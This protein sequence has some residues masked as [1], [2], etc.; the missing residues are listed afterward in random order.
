M[1]AM[2]SCSILILMIDRRNNG[3]LSQFL[4]FFDFL[5]ESFFEMC[6]AKQLRL[7]VNLGTIAERSL[8]GTLQQFV[9]YFYFVQRMY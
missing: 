8:Y 5:K 2:N 9:P 3:Y 4:F 6:E 7:R 1:H